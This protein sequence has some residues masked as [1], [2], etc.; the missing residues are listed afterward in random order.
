[1]SVQSN[2]RNF[3]AVASAA[4]F[5]AGPAALAQDI[6]SQAHPSAYTTSP[7]AAGVGPVS[8][9][10]AQ[11]PIGLVVQRTGGSLL[12]AE[13]FGKPE[14]GPLTTSAVSFYD[15]PEP[16]PKLLRKHDLVTI[17]IRENSQFS[18]ND[19]TNLKHSNDLDAV[20]DSYVTLGLTNGPAL[21]E[22]TPSTPIELKTSGQRDFKGTANLERDDTFTGRITAEVIDVKPNGTL[23]LQATEEIKTD[24]EE[25]RVT[26]IGTCR[27]EDVTAD[28]TVLSNQLYNLNLNKQHKG[29]VKDTATR[30]LWTRLL[31]WINPF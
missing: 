3:I 15:V 28:N 6:P 7:Q 4:I 31:D 9:G 12:R 10:P 5:A 26:L 11:M 8:S 2:N 13:S 16:K 30:G 22:H 29:A 19:T 17:V 23:V 25:Q 14:G 1:M 18:S 20:I 27:V 24:E 21:N